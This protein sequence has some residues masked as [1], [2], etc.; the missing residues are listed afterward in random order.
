M[1][2]ISIVIPFYNTPTELFIECL[3]SVKKLKP[4]E[5]I[6]V[7]DC[8]T[9]QEVIAIAKNSGYK[10]LK[11]TYQSGFDGHPFNVGVQSAQGDYV[12]RVD[13][14]DILLDLP[15]Q[16]LFD[17]HFGK[18]KRVAISN[19]LRIEDLIL[20]PRAIFNA[21]V[22]KKELLLQYPL[23]EDPNVFADVLLVLRLLYN[24]YSYDVH[25]QVNY[26]YRK[27]ENS[28]QTSQSSFHHRLRHIQTVA[29]FCYLENI[30]PSKSLYYLKL[31]MLNTKY[32]SDSRKFYHKMIQRRKNSSV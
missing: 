20:A 30:S 13:S 16:M 18:A 21:L 8:S 14:D 26:I 5:V 17:I 6:L 22:V 9:D 25:D 27:R 11:T 1:L 7:D 19:N 32:G 10:Y 12:C 24:K 23:A 15:T 28:I 3:E 29:R 4:F 2:K 31:A